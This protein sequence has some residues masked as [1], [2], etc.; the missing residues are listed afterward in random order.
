MVPVA[1][2]SGKKYVLPNHENAINGSYPLA[3]IL[4][5]YINKAPNKPLEPVVKEFLT[6][7][8]SK[9][10]QSGVAK[11]GYIPLPPKIADRYLKLLN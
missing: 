2:K 3:R 7:V 6:L 1:K 4:Y 9:Q 8:L 11:D 10:G 5:V